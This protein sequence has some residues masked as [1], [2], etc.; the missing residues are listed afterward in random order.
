MAAKIGDRVGAIASGNNKTGLVLLGYGVY[1]GDFIP[2]DG[3]GF[4]A[5]TLR[6]LQRTNPRI[7]LDSGETVYGCECWWGSETAIQT[8]E[9][10]YKE[11]GLPVRTVSVAD[12]RRQSNEPRA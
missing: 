6:E 8:E 2:E 12:F 11:D 9:S 3:A 1:E 10:R 4:M 7:R 5:E